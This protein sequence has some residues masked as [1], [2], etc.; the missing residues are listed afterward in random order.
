MSAFE[1]YCGHGPVTV[2]VTVLEQV[3]HDAM[4]RL[5]PGLQCLFT[6]YKTA[7]F[8][9]GPSYPQPSCVLIQTACAAMQLCQRSSLIRDRDSDRDCGF[10]HRVR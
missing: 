2:T 6:S 4:Q 5:R 3:E 10:D 1:K 7:G 9:P 8:L